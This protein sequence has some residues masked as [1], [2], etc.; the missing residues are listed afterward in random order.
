MTS[1]VKSAVLATALLAG[2]IASGQKILINGGGATFPNPIYSKWFSEYNKKFPNIQINYQSQGSSFGVAQITAGTVDFGA[3]DAPMTD[4]QIKAF[5]DKHG[6]G[7]LHFPTV[8]GGNAPIYNI[9]GVTAQLNFTGDALSGIFLGKITKWNDP[10]LTKVNPGANLPDKP[11]IV[12]HRSDGSGT[13]YVWTDYLSKVS[14]EWETKVGRG[15]SPNW[16]VGLGG[17]GSEG[18]TGQVKQQPNSIGYVEVLYALQNKLAFG[19]VKNQA[20]NFVGADLVGVTAAA[21]GAMKEIPDDF[22]VS[23]T[24][25]PGK[26]SYPISTFTWLLIPEKIAD[27]G[28]QK[29][30]KDFVTWALKDGSGFGQSF[31]E[32]LQFAKLPK[33]V[34]DKEV[35]AIAKIQ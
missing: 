23:I 10:E 5:K 20:G 9:P 22:R 27:S 6:Y 15:N 1:T 19:K 7:I 14:K 8:M 16:P 11:I 21:A 28:K 33:A 24:N 30:I 32:A 2:G 31:C 3:S 35:K 25:A 4:D 29:A 34:I 18:V 12:V 26:N 13:T 17:K